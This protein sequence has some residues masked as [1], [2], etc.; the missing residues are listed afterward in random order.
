M[1]MVNDTN[2]VFYNNVEV[3]LDIMNLAS[4]P[5]FKIKSEI[6]NKINVLNGIIDKL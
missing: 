4:K 6:E 1:A 2:N 3:T 5:S